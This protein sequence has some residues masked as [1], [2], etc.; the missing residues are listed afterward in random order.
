MMFGHWPP[1]RPFQG[2]FVDFLGDL[3]LLISQEVLLRWGSGGRF[4]CHFG[5]SLYCVFPKIL[6]LFWSFFVDFLALLF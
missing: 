1:E 6:T 3:K 4:Q 2:G 5:G